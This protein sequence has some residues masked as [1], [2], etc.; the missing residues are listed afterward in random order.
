MIE[1]AAF[2]NDEFERAQEGKL[3]RLEHPVFQ[4]CELSNIEFGVVVRPL[5]GRQ[6]AAAAGSVEMAMPGNRGGRSRMLWN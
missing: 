1:V 4:L 5:R 3:R 6:Q 2:A